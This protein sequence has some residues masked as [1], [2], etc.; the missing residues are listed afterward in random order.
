[1]QAEQASWTAQIVAFSRVAMAS[2]HVGVL[3]AEPFTL[4]LLPKP[5]RLLAAAMR[6]PVAP[7]V[8]R[9]LERLVGAMPFLAGRARFYDESL[10]AALASDIEQFA[11]LAAGLDVRSLRFS[12]PGRTFFEVDHPATQAFKRAQLASSGTVTGQGPTF[13]AIDFEV[14]D[15][16]DALVA[17]GFDP[18]RRAFFLLEGVTMY[19]TPTDIEKTLGR[20][21]AVAA[22]GSVLCLDA[23]F[24]LQRSQV[25]R[26][27]GVRRWVVKRKGEPFKGKLAPEEMGRILAALGFDTDQVMDVYALYDR[28]CEGAPMQPPTT[29]MNY[30]LRATRRRDS[31]MDGTEPSRR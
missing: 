21:A 10:Q 23:T 18:H 8:W 22:P 5:M 19:L 30:V 25:S 17:S 20:I 24:P 3:P 27:Q 26:M 7:V 14:S 29:R 13:V 6:T 4:S 1:M 31:S 15:F 11:I 16:G 2:D 12:A 9:G 28:Y